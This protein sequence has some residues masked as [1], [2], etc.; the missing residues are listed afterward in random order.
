MSSF[1]DDDLVYGSDSDDVIDAGGG[2]DTVIAGGG[3]DVIY[4]RDAGSDDVD[5]GAGDDRLVLDYSGETQDYLVA[6]RGI[7]SF[8]YDAQGNYLNRSGVGYEV[9]APANTARWGINSANY[10]VIYNDIEHLDVT[11]TQYA[12]FLLGGNGDDL[13]AG[14][15][16]DDFLIGG[17]GNDT[18][19]GNAGDDVLDGGPGIDTA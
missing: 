2:N 6:G 1:G 4:Q 7:W 10:G 18:L 8:Y 11:G 13:L 9:A 12:D 15:R 14:G 3:N 17:L 16:D 19:E 5:G